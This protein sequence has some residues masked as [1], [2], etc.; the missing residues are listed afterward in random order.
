FEGVQASTSIENQWSS[1]LKTTVHLGYI[2]N[3]K[4]APGTGEGYSAALEAAYKIGDI[5]IKPLAGIY[6]NE[7]D[8]LPAA[9][10]DVTNALGKTNRIAQSYLL[11]VAVPEQNYSFYGRYVQTDVLNTDTASN[12]LSDRRIISLG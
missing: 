11:R 1:P 8:V 7:S 9:Y 2:L 12:I 4:A 6:Y 5:E 3:R 10:A